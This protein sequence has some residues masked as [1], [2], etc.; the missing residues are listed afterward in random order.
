MNEYDSK[1]SEDFLKTKL[2]LFT[3]YFI[4]KWAKIHKSVCKIKNCN[5]TS[6][7][8]ISTLNNLFSII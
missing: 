6:K 4:K 7:L 8:L 2:N 3:E 5:D 1:A